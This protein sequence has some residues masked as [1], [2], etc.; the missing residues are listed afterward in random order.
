MSAFSRVGESAQKTGNR[1][2]I[3]WAKFFGE[4]P[5]KGS[6][7]QWTMP[8]DVGTIAILFN[9]KFSTKDVLRFGKYR[10]ADLL[11]ETLEATKSS[12]RTGAVAIHEEETGRPT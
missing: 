1:F 2:E 9:L 4:K 10:V 3:F 6:G 5:V 12:D 7:N 8:L 11:K